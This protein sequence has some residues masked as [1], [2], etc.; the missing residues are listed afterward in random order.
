MTTAEEPAPTHAPPRSLDLPEPPPLR[1]LVGPGIV[2]VGIGMAAGEIILWPHLITTGGL[3]LLWLALATLVIQ[4]GIN[5]EI[6]RYTLATGQTVVAGFSRWWTGWGVLICLAAAF[7][8]MWPGWA[9]SG[10]TVLT[11]A[12][13]GGDAVWI[14]VA[15]LVVMGALLTVSPVIYRTLEKVELVKVGATLFFLAVIVVAVISWRTW[16]QAAEETVTGVGRIPEGVTFTMLLGGLGAAGAGGVHNLVLSN[17]IR[18][19]GYGMGAHVPR[20]VSPITG[21]T[22]AAGADR[23]A[24][25]QDEANL[26]RWRVWWRR[27]NVEHIVSFGVVC[28]LSISLMSMLAYQTL[29]GRDGVTSDPS[30][31]RTQ[32]EVLGTETGRWLEI[33]FY[34]VAVVSLW[35]ASIGL[36]DIMG[37][38]V[39]DFVR[40]TYLARS[41]FWT[42]GRLY[43]TAVWTEIVLGSAILLSGVDQPMSLL[44][45]STCTAS[46]VTL[47]YSALL[48]RLNRRDLPPA[49][50]LRGGRL[51]FMVLAVGFYGFFA[52]AMVVTQLRDNL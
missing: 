3:G 40:R 12:V 33:L 23:Y 7:Q 4:T 35:A 18:D 50:R 48:I 10:S 21:Q 32:A 46:V 36:L 13:G 31:L 20:L 39:S 47:L 43:V 49:V 11:Y 27:A 41:T 6:E 28:L 38:V 16:G 37:R 9:T 45:I 14:T 19:K 22:E 8:Y 2:A 24:F 34:S 30:F 17:W 42:E 1:R 44:L 5:L 26:A 52:T 25:P 51:G 29:S 15:A